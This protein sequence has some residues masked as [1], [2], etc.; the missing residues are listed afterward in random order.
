MNNE[1]ILQG[2]LANTGIKNSSE[3]LLTFLMENTTDI[4]FYQEIRE[5][6]K[7]INSALDWEMILSTTSS[8][9]TIAG[10]L[11]AAYKKFIIPLKN[12]NK[13]AFIF[14]QVRNERNQFIQFSIGKEDEDEETFIRSFTEKVEKIRI[15]TDSEKIEIENR[16]MSEIRG[17]IH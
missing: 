1:L 13:N 3:E 11:W 10:A 16:E 15:R 14:V 4:E 9:I 2:A 5:S 8:I 17:K 7:V 12:K 6:G